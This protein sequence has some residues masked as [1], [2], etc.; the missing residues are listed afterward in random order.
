MVIKAY[1]YNRAMMDAVLKYM[2]RVS[3]TYGYEISRVPGIEIG[4]VDLNLDKVEYPA[5]VVIDHQ[6][7]GQEH[8]YE[9][10][11]AIIREVERCDSGVEQLNDDEAVLMIVDEMSDGSPLLNLFFDVLV[12]YIIGND[13]MG[14]RSERG[15]DGES[16]LILTDISMY[17][18]Q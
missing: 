10:S 12:K 3:D 11:Y 15:V 8:V 7:E 2:E 4:I 9:N 13:I 5:L 1:V 16:I 18:H 14:I 6:G 17:D